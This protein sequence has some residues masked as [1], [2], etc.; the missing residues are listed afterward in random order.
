MEI[1]KAVHQITLESIRPTESVIGAEVKIAE[2]KKII[3]KYGWFGEAA[4]AVQDETDGTIYLLD[5]HHRLAAAQEFGLTEIPVVIVEFSD[6]SKFYLYYNSM[7]SVRRAA[8]DVERF[9]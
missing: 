9:R 5:G 2:I 3:E 4:I 7:E 6:L 1:D 8:N